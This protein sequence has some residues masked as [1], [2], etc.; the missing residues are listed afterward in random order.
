MNSSGIKR[1]LATAAITAL[2]VTGVPSI[3]SANTIDAQVATGVTLYNTAAT[4]VSVKSDGVNTTVRLEAGAAAAITSVTFQY[5]LNG[6]DFVDITTTGRNDDGA[7]STEWNAAFLAGATVTLRVIQTGNVAVFDSAAGVAILGGGSAVD[8]FN[9]TDGSAKGVYQSPITGDDSVIVDGTTSSTTG[10]VLIAAKGG[11]GSDAYTGTAV[12]TA[13]PAPP[14]AATGGTFKGVLDIDGYTFS[15]DG[16]ADQLVVEAS[17]AA[18]SEDFE[19]YTLYKQ[20]I[21]TVTATA[22]STTVPAG[23]PANITVTV[24]DQSGAPIAGAQV[25]SSTGEDLGET[26]ASGQVTDTQAAGDG[27]TYYYANATVQ[28][29]YSAGQGDKR[30][31]DITVTDFTP[32]PTTLVATSA[33]GPAF[34]LDENVLADITVQVKNQNGGNFDPNDVQ[35]LRYYW[36]V[37]PFDGTPATQRVPATLTDE[38][39]V[40]IT[41]GKFQV[42]LPTGL[43]DESG[44]YEL[45]AALEADGGGNNAIASS[46]VLTIKAGEADITFDETSP[47]SAVAGSEE[48]VDGQLVL[49]DGTGLPGRSVVL[50]YTRGTGSDATPD[51]GFVP[52]PPAAPSAL[53]LSKTVTTGADGSF[54][55]TV[56][57]PAE[58]APA[59]QGTELGGNVDADSATTGANSDQAVDFVSATPPADTTVV[60]TDITG[61]KPGV[62]TAVSTATVTTPDGIDGGT[63]RDPVVGQQ[64]TVTIDKGFFTTGTEKV[65]SVFGADAGNLVNL[66]QSITLTTDADGKVTFRTAI[67]RDAG[68]DDDGLV[69]STVTA[70]AGTASDTEDVD[71][72]SAAPLNGGTVEIAL[73]PESEQDG[74]T[75]PAMVGDRVFFDV[76]VTDQFG[77]LVGGE[78]VVITDNEEDTNIFTSPVASDFDDNGDF[79]VTAS[80]AAQA[81]I[82]GTWSSDSYEYT[83]TTGTAAPAADEPRTGTADVEFYESVVTT[84]TIESSPEGEVPVGT[85]VTE[86]VT[87]LDQEG[88]PIQG[89]EVE[90]IRN[91][92][93]AGDGD[94]N[95][96]R[97]TNAQ[98]KA[99]YTFIGTQ[100]GVA[101]ITATVTSD[102]GIETLN[103]SVVF[104][105]EGPG[106]VDERDPIKAFLSGQDNGP[107]KDKLTVKAPAKAA[108]AEVRLF[109]VVKGKRIQVGNTKGLNAAGDATFIVKDTNGGRLTKYVA[110]VVKTAT[111]L[112]DTTNPKRVR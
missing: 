9:V 97:F 104:V 40:E 16:S 11:D 85:A 7:F 52:A 5:S 58:A 69:K 44:T 48:V 82:T 39:A 77:N 10:P 89:V 51:A 54:T 21:T 3:A 108:G 46:K 81:T 71:F 20:V 23:T 96:V 76:F 79:Y 1:G 93:G 88:N 49:E 83:N 15:G 74:P 37:T 87:V 109:K 4:P 90:F 42:P 47:E 59:T 63:D 41:P 103:D 100:E 32:A 66:G 111:T 25:Y 43:T 24:L 78:S 6:T 107:A 70:S 112:S 62:A 36:V 106:P 60:I 35:D 73:S 95:V 56:D 92:P 17:Q 2:A 102:D 13:T 34:D 84:T 22:D 28:P 38:Q 33:D 110:V 53:T 19:G 75:D 45:F 86:T 94:A 18:E 55:V 30:S 99:F 31:A 72:N 64:V 12:V 50:T 8:A 27:T 91:G 57:D 80:Q 105:G 67:E 61:S 14:A 98:G 26:D 68:F 29:E 101:N 65:P